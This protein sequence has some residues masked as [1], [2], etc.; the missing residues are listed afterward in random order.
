MIDISGTIGK[1]K[2]FL[3]ITQN[4][5]WESTKGVFTDPTANLV[6]GSSKEGS[7]LYVIQGL[8]R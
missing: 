5:G 2:T 1:D 6:E 8:D 7:Q 3:L 4:H